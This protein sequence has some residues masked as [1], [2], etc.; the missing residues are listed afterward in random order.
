VSVDRIFVT[1]LLDAYDEDVVNDEPRIVLRL[2]PNMAP[3]PVALCP[4][5]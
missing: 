3:V 1:L 5:P 4:C 2:H